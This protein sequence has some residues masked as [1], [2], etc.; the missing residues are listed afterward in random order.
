MLRPAQLGTISGGRRAL[1]VS[2]L[3]LSLR[4]SGLPP[5][6]PPRPPHSNLPGTTKAAPSPDAPIS[7][8]P[9]TQAPLPSQPA[10]SPPSDP[11]LSKW[12]L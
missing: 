7:V 12:P 3:P 9:Q 1:P 4:V 2:D 8:S 11:K 6:T 10:S 5:H